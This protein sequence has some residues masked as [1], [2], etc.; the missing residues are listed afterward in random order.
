MCEVSA[1]LQWRTDP[2][3]RVGLLTVTSHENA[4]LH[5]LSGYSGIPRIKA[6]TSFIMS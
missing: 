5:I 6:S 1:D 3:R 4:F 2:P